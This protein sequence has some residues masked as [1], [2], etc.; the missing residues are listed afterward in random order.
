MAYGYRRVWRSISPS[1]FFG[2]FK[3]AAF[4]FLFLWLWNILRN[5]GISGLISSV[6]VGKG[7]TS[8]VDESRKFVD[9]GARLLASKGV[10]VTGADTQNANML[11][12][13][14]NEKNENPFSWAFWIQKLKTNTQLKVLA[15]LLEHSTEYDSKGTCI[16]LV[17][18]NTAYGVRTCKNRSYPIVGFVSPEKEGNLS[19]HLFMYMSDSLPQSGSYAGAVFN[20]YL[21]DYHTV[22]VNR[23]IIKILISSVNAK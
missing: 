21:N 10:T 11:F 23:D 2:W 16:G 18:L 17:R 13:L 3:L 9:A 22:T 8:R 19:D 1:R 20:K 14:L 4:A 12:D 5:R 15:L 6:F 7:D